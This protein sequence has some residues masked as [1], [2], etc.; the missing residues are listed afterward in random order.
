MGLA[1]RMNDETPY[2]LNSKPT[3]LADLLQDSKHVDGE[4]FSMCLS[5][6]GGYMNMGIS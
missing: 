6:H 4:I 3:I 2:D 5:Q 1:G